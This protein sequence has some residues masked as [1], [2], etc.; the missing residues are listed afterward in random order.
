MLVAIGSTN[1]V[2]IAAVKS[3]FKKVW[4]RKNF[5]FFSIKVRSIVSRQPMSDLENIKGA[6]N[7]AK[8]ALKMFKA[9]FG[10]GVE[11]G[12]QK[13]GN[14][15]FDSGWVVIIDK[16]G[17]EGVGSSVKMQTPKE[18]MKLVKKGKEL[19]EVDDL[20]FKQRNSKQKE[21]HFGLMTK[22]IIT[23]KDGYTDA[24]I[25][26]LIRFIHTSLFD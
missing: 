5:K 7:R 21:G 9:D 12:L 1:P 15:W 11:G 24:V 19:G 23:R 22:N 16:N 26:A 2:K 17:A 6:R 8:I 18:M 10:V 4:S 20:I 14:K 3:A 13:I 25:S